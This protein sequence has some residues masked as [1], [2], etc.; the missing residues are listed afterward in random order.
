[1]TRAASDLPA[2]EALEAVRERLALVG[3]F[4]AAQDADVLLM[5]RPENLAW[6]TLGGDLRVSREAGSVADA[7]ITSDGI[8]LVTSRI[9]AERI[10]AEVLPPLAGLD[11]VAWEDPAARPR[12]LARHAAGRRTVSDGDHDLA[13][14]RLPLLPFERRRFEAIGSAAAH[15]L[16]DAVDAV[17][18]DWSE[19]RVAVRLHATLREAGLELPVVLVGG[20]ERFGRYRHPLPTDAPLGPFGLLVVCAQRHGLVVSLSRAVAFGEVPDV[21]AA[22]LE[23]VLAVESAMLQA[24][25][26]GV[27][28][29]EVFEAAREGYAAVGHAAAWRDHHQGGPAGYLPRE[30]LATPGERR[31]IRAEVPVAW[32]PSLPFA[33]SED[34]FWLSEDGLTNLTWDPRWPARPVTG[35]QRAWVRTL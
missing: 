7:V 8:T 27:T 1:V 33:K 5:H 34:T 23:H 17:E 14:L 3:A 20:A 29:H 4:L 19:H 32:N 11:V 2:A 10:E 21:L 24:T 16:T 31:T 25:V 28:G 12:A 15:A 35:R 22:R 26:P 30:W 6:I 18:P 13:H 9:E